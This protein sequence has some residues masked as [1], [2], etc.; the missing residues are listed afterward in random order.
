MTSFQRMS[1][2]P[3]SKQTQLPQVYK[4]A[5]LN[6]SLLS[7]LASLGTYIQSHK[8]T[9]A[10]EAFNTVVRTVYKNLDHAISILK[11]NDSDFKGN[12]PKEELAMHFTALK[13]ISE[14]EL[15]EVTL[16]DKEAFQLKMQEAQLVIEQLIWLINLSENISKTT[17]I[18]KNT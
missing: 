11:E 18:L 8:T 15:K 6:H 4:L 17:K 5:V 13:S 1:Q 14:K 9:S 2:E 3:K 12:T 7:S 16:I 10:S